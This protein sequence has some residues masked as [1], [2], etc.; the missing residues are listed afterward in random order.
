MVYNYF[1]CLF[2]LSYVHLFTVY[3]VLTRMDLQPGKN[4]ERQAE[5]RKQ[6]KSTND[7]YSCSYMYIVWYLYII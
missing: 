5:E 3:T 7:M 4:Q 2:T 1:A 6:G